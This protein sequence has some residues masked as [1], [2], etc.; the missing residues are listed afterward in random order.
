MRDIDIRQT[1]M[2]EM[3]RLHQGDSETLIVEELGLCQ[4]MAR[5]DV[6]VVNGSLHGY[7]I[8]SE[9]DTLFRLPGQ[10][11][12][13]NRALDFVTIIAASAHVEKIHEMIPRWWGIWKAAQKGTE[14][15]LQKVRT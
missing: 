2:N 8:K 3:C 5:V 14:V 1:L 13:Y 12:V 9:R 6:A 11:D 7:E 15:Q 4:G 10:R